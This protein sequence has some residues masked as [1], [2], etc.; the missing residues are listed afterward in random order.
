MSWRS[1][2]SEKNH[3]RFILF[4]YLFFIKIMPIVRKQKLSYKTIYRNKENCLN[5]FS[6]RLYDMPEN[7]AL[8]VLLLSNIVRFDF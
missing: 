2:E 1:Y 4:I 6:N 3:K 8:L 7:V 5:I